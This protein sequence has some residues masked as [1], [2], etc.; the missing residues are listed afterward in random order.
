[1]STANTP[2][3]TTV[4]HFIEQRL[5]AIDQALL[6]MLPRHERLAVVAQ[7]ETRLRDQ[8]AMNPAIA[9]GLGELRRGPGL[10]DS[11][12]SSL[13]AATPAF[14]PHPQPF[15][16][17][18][19]GWIPATPKRRSWIAVSAGILGIVAL[20][21]MFATPITFF[22]VEMFAEVL[23]EFGAYA[24]LGTHTFMVGIGG[25]AAI[26]LGICALLILRRKREQLA[27]HGWA[28]AG[29]CTGSLPMLTGCAALLFTALQLGALQ[30]FSI[31]EAPSAST[32]D[33]P[34]ASES[35][36]A[37]GP[38]ALSVAP[39]CPTPMGMSF[40]PV[41]TAPNSPPDFSQ[42]PIYSAGHDLPDFAN[43]VRAEGDS[44]LVPTPPAPRNL[45]A[46][47]PAQQAEPLKRTEPQPATHSEPVPE[48]VPMPE[49][50]PAIS[51]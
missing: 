14:L 25:M 50:A 48:P 41:A 7:L 10:P 26:G 6:G 51:R 19:G 21:L 4:Q 17:S 36:D 23:G 9:A 11:A 12:L 20:V 18:A 43:P 13:S 42:S 39:M 22:I 16:T 29:L 37:I 38:V 1:M 5:D 45:P 32:A 27:G 2:A 44:G 24:L 28:I 3:Q 31:S 15:A 8:A 35:K 46:P 47:Q 30:F 34:K 33:S 49:S 40:A